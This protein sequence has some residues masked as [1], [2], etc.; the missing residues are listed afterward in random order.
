MVNSF[1]YEKDYT[2]FFIVFFKIFINLTYHSVDSRHSPSFQEER[3]GMSRKIQLLHLNL[4]HHYIIS[5]PSAV[6]QLNIKKI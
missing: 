3:N 1:L 6:I 4:R 2:L 5:H